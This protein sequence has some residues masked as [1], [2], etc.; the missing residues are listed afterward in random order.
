M[1]CEGETQTID[2]PPSFG[3]PCDGVVV[4]RFDASVWRTE[5]DEKKIGGG[6]ELLF[7]GRGASDGE[8]TVVG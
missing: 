8:G 1:G 7:G 4:Q 6:G 2:P 5:E 3:V